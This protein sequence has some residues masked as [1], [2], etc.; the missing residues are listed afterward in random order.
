MRSLPDPVACLTA[1]TS[2]SSLRRS[3]SIVDRTC[4]RAW[5]LSWA[6]RLSCLFVRSTSPPRS[7]RT[8]VT[9]RSSFST[10]SSRSTW[11]S[12]GAAAGMR[13]GSSLDDSASRADVVAA[14]RV[15]TASRFATRS[16][17]ALASATAAV[18]ASSTLADTSLMSRD[19][20]AASSL[21]DVVASAA[22]L[23]SAAAF[24]AAPS[25]RRTSCA[26]DVF[27]SLSFVC[28]FTRSRV[29]AAI[30][31]CSLLVRLIDSS[32]AMRRWERSL[33]ASCSGVHVSSSE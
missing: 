20:R 13:G 24:P 17:C 31:C 26:S 14:A 25:A 18:R 29:V 7:C 21:N 15:A 5:S 2:A 6:I 3:R 19:N 1:A 27:V 30:C 28:A 16:A 4:A 10:A 12:V 8:E 23:A 32:T 11:L 9:L 22:C 33:L